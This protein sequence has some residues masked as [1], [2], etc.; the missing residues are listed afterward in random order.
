MNKM[1]KIELSSLVSGL[2]AI[3]LGVVMLIFQS[4]IE[5]LWIVLPIS[6]IGFGGILSVMGIVMIGVRLTVRKG[7]GFAKEIADNDKN[8]HILENDERIIAILHKATY[9]MRLY[10]GWLDSALLMFLIIMQVE[11]AVT[12]VFLAVVL[13]R[14]IVFAVLRRKYDREM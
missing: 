2:S 14:I 12:L 9:N 8:I 1:V 10:T 5:G 7:S 11:L 4:G 6:I 13:V 3:L